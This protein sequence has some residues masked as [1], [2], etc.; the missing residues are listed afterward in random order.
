MLG[1]IHRGLQHQHAEGYPRDPGDEADDG[2]DAEKGEDYR[3]R[4]VVTHEIV[5]R[6]SYTKDNIQDTGD[7]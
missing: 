6:G 2:E 1:D 5:R 4:V 3:G 7:P